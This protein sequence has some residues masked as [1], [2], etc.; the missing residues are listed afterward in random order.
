VFTPAVSSSFLLR[1]C[2]ARDA[3]K[4]TWTSAAISKA[5]FLSLCSAGLLCFKLLRPV[6]LS[7]ELLRSWA[8]SPSACAA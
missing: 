7:T 6:L 8:F 3:P 1:L 5:L 4:H 2:Y